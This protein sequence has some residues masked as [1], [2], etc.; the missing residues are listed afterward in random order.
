VNCLAVRDRLTEH[1]LGVLPRSEAAA[2]DRHLEWCA[3]CRKEAGELERA[4]AT[5]A[6]TAAP[7]EP[8]VDL[9]DRVVEAVRREA[10]RR[11]GA[12]PRRKAWRRASALLAA[13]L[14]LSGLSWGAVMAGRADKAQEQRDALESSQ[15][16]SIRRFQD[17]IE[18]LEGAD[19]ANIVELATLLP[20]RGRPGGGDALVLL[21]PSAN[22]LVLVMLRGIGS[23]K[24]GQLPLEVRLESERAGEIVV[25]QI[26]SLDEADGGRVYGTFAQDLKAFGWLVV[27]D[28]RG[29][30]LLRGNLGVFDSTA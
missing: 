8:P 18:R 27:R 4:A 1:A 9:E 17:V 19:P 23:V 25:G 10:G 30:E 6:Y 21:S 20:T 13:T 16:E 22:D 24:D 7:V 28:A 11:G 26:A 2:V 3:A 5:L 15:K 14:A 12:A 29:K